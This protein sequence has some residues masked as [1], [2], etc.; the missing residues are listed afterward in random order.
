VG[1]LL[2]KK[3]L[4]SLLKKKDSEKLGITL[5]V[6]LQSFV[7]F[8]LASSY[9]KAILR[10]ARTLGPRPTNEIFEGAASKFLW[11]KISSTMY[12]R[13]PFV[14]VILRERFGLTCVK[15]KEEVT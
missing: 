3:R 11:S 14:V 4:D 2:S 6:L 5:Q 12:S 15:G 9:P 7:V 8:E 13:R 1:R 10:S